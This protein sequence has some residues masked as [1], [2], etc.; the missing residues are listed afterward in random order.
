MQLELLIPFERRDV[1]KTLVLQKGEKL[2]NAGDQKGVHERMGDKKAVTRRVLLKGE[3][4]PW[5]VGSSCES[6]TTLA[7]YRVVKHKRYGNR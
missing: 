4:K 2:E 1:V 7:P 3:N 6:E 5:R